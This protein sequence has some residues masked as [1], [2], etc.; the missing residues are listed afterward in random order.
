MPTYTPDANNVDRP[1]GG[2]RALIPAELRSIK[3][4]LKSLDDNKLGKSGAYTR[5]APSGTN[6]FTATG[7][8]NVFVGQTNFIKYQVSAD[9]NWLFIIDG[10]QPEE[11]EIPHFTLWLMNAGGKTHTFSSPVRWSEGIPPSFTTNGVD[12]LVF[13]KPWPTAEFWYGQQVM[14]DVKVS[15]V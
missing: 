15:G 9:T 1:V 5:I 10:P 11:N 7:H 2:D 6:R 12:V 4:K 13:F 8:T 14:K 3:A